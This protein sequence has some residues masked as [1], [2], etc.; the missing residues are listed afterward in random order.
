MPVEVPD[1]LLQQLYQCKDCAKEGIGPLPGTEFNW[2]KAA[3]Y[4]NGVRRDAY[5]KRHQNIRKVAANKKA[6]QD[7]EVN[8]RLLDYY[9]GRRE[10]DQPK[11]R[12]RQ[13]RWRKKHPELAASHYYDWLERNR[14]KR[15]ESQ[16]AYRERRRVRGSQPVRRKRRPDE[17]QPNE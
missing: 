5:C 1:E 15:K 3:R 11:A 16:D 2:V 12:L 10:K 6:R 9:K 14:A 4:K 7:P 13:A 17:E 8:Q